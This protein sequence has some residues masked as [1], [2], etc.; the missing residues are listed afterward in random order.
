MSISGET[1]AAVPVDKADELRADIVNTR[2]ELADTLD[3]L[4]ARLDVK[5]RA[6]HQLAGA[7]SSARIRLQ[8]APQPVQQAAAAL[9]RLAQ[10]ARPYRKQLAAAATGMLLIALVARRR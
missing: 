7:K 3:R 2:A 5:S 4:A 6:R 10:Q 1:P 8:N 9:A